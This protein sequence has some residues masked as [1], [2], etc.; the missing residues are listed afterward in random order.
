M[1]TKNLAINLA[2]LKVA[3]EMIRRGARPPLVAASTGVPSGVLR[4]IWSD[5]HQR[6]PPHGLLPDNCLGII[7]RYKEIIHA[8][9]FYLLYYREGQEDVFRHAD[10]QV[11]LK[12]HDAYKALVAS[13]QMQEVLDFTACWYIARDLRSRI[14]EKRYCRT[15]HI[16]HLYCINQK[17]MH[18]CPFCH[19]HVKPSRIR[20]TLLDTPELAAS[21][22]NL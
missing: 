22:V 8:N 5:H 3:E 13:M 1:R 17:L 19:L 11:V 15:C 21:V 9:L 18:T 4:D 14:L 2:A 7:R 16:N 12:A 10:D 6:R 20:G